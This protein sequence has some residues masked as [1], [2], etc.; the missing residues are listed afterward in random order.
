MLAP[1][2]GAVNDDRAPPT[3]HTL[4]AMDPRSSI[5][6]GPWS[7][8][9]TTDWRFLLPSTRDVGPRR[10]V[11]LAGATDVVDADVRAT[12]PALEVYRDRC[13]PGIAD[14]AAIFRGSD[15]PIAMVEQM[16]APD[17]LLY[18]E[19]ARSRWRRMRT[20]PAAARTALRRAGLAP[21]ETYWVTSGPA[22]PSMHLPLGHDGA[23][24]WY[25]A[26]HHGPS[27]RVRRSV[28]WILRALAKGRGRR[29][30]RFVPVFAVTARRA[31][32]AGDAEPL[33]ATALAG[34][35]APPWA[36]A[37]AARPI[38][39]GGGEGPWSRA[40]LL[41]FERG[42]DEPA[43]VIKIARGGVYAGSLAA[44]QAVLAKLQAT[45]RHEIGTRVPL[46]LGFVSL[47]GQPGSAETYRP[48]TS[49][50]VRS[51]RW[52]RR[53][54]TMRHDLERAAAWLCDL[55]DATATGSTNL[56]PSGFDLGVRIDRYAGVFGRD[57]VEDR[58][59]RQLHV[60]T[61][62]GLRFPRVLRHRD[63]GPWNVLV[64][65][66][67]QVSVIDW[68]VAGDGPPL[69]DL[70]YFVTHWCWIAAGRGSSERDAQV[71]RRLLSGEESA[72]YLEAGRG[73]IA[74]HARRL[75]LDAQTVAALVA[76]TFIEQALDRHDRLAAIGDTSATDR[77]SNRYV[78]YVSALAE[79][80]DLA[81]AIA[82]WLGSTGTRK[83]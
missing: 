83:P 41:P 21:I 37:H 35:D 78:R 46:P 9:R 69:I 34:A 73:A 68:E 66:E 29:L 62:G 63:Y 14:V 31:A 11:L 16:L 40:V 64:D 12:D 50:S 44:E 39:L 51:A 4:A 48:G 30:E 24:R 27:S 7:A 22:G 75:G 65:A 23:V 70:V 5:N 77:S 38:L 6:D 47:L 13:G 82:S 81:G 17:G 57:E 72:W 36:T 33:A 80:S 3:A 76:W 42:G 20:S 61:G 49:V 53:S 43:G 25:F 52:R 10:R 18:W 58:W 45:E 79:V 26:Q 2:R 54:T 32:S 67:G 15:A 19:V 71:L 55:H 28:G 8:A 1:T 60:A 56:G 59:F 74:G